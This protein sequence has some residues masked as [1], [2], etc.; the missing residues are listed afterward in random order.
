M[1]TNLLYGPKFGHAFDVSRPITE[2][3]IAPICP[4]VTLYGRPFLSINS[5]LTYL[6]SAY[7]NIFN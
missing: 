6:R 5:H 1:S 4:N 7:Y 2:L 3:I